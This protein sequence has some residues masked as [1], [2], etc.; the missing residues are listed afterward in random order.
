M[1]IYYII[2]YMNNN[3]MHRLAG[4]MTE[5]LIAVSPK[6]AAL[7]LENLAT[8]EILL[9]VRPLKAHVLVACLN[10]MSTPKAAAVIRRIPL[11]QAAY[12]L[13]HL[14][15]EQAASLWKEFAVPYQ[16]RLRTVLD[17]SFVTF[18]QNA[19]NYPSFSAGRLMQTDFISVRTD[20]KAGELVE[21]LKSL[22]RSKLPSVC[23]V[24]GKDGVLKG[25]IRTIELSFYAKESLCGSFMTDTEKL[26]VDTLPEQAREIFQKSGLSVLPVVD[27][28]TVLLGILD[29]SALPREEKNL[30]NFLKK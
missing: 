15:I 13:A 10:E 18:I 27:K 5:H 4:L 19:G 26:V 14:K 21:K 16:E 17:E 29:K 22:P 9:L 2:N 6:E 3:P 23:F 30:W 12:I 28:N 20:T 25:I 8:H 24:T 7:V 1:L 11:K